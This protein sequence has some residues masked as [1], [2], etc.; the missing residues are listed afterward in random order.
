MAKNVVFIHG[1]WIHSTSWKPWQDLF[2]E[3]GYT[4]VAPGW[5][6]DLDTVEATRATPDGLNNQ[7]I[8]GST[9]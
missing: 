4:T 6:G 1:L 2:E 9:A 8:A 5:P 7:G 3:K